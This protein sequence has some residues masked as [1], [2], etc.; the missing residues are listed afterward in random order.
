MTL[1]GVVALILPYFTEFGRYRGALQNL[2]EDS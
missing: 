2:V 1:N